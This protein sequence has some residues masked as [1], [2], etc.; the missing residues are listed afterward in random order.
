MNFMILTIFFILVFQYFSKEVSLTFSIMYFK[1]PMKI[2]E[3]TSFLLL[4]IIYFDAQFFKLSP[5][6]ARFLESDNIVKYMT[7]LN[8]AGQVC[9]EKCV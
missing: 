8:L 4:D 9:T 6:Q 7:T 5:L 3:R 1:D 2:S